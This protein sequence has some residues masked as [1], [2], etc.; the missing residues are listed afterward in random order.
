MITKASTIREEELRALKKRAKDMEERLCSLMK[1]IG[2]FE[3]DPRPST[4]RSAVDPEKC[5]ACG[6]CLELCPTGA[7]S[8]DRIA[9]ID[10][11]RCTG[12]GRCVEA[13][14]Q[15]ALRWQ[16]VKG[17]SGEMTRVAS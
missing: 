3:H 15:G 9:H 7:I 12:C 14:P 17:V 1:R 13:C 8:I 16:R 4:Y 5:I 11:T 2:A 10:P 6:T